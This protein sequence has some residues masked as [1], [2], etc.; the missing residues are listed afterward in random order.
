MEDGRYR[1]VVSSH[2]LALSSNTGTPSVH[3]TFST[4]YNISNPDA[5]VNQTMY[6]DLWLTEKTFDRTM[7]TLTK[8]FGWAGGDLQEL[9]DR[10][11]LLTGAECVLVV[12][13]EE[14]EGK[15]SPK[16]KF[17][18]DIQKRLDDENARA[19]SHKF[20]GKLAAYKQKSPGVK[21]GVAPV[22]EVLFSKVPDN[23]LPAPWDDTVEQSHP[24]VSEDDLPY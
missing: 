11:L 8:T 18:N 24:S 21:S 6:A 10:P 14:H 13:N 15:I 12:E 9:N 4:K 5:P 19:I 3:V 17:V 23:E 7:H 16:V 22:S 2:S 1:A 20:A